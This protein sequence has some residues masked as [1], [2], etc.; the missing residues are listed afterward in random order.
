[1]KSRQV[2]PLI[3]IKDTKN[4]SALL[5]WLKFNAAAYRTKSGY[6]NVFYQF[7]YKSLSERTGLSLSTLYKYV[8]KLIELGWAH[9]R[10]GNLCL[11]GINKYKGAKVLIPIHRNRSKQI[12]EL[13]NAIIVN[14]L[15]KQERQIKFRKGIVQKAESEHGKLTKG[16]LKHLR[17]NPNILTEINPSNLSNQKFG[18]LIDRSKSTG[19]RLQRALRKAKLIQS[20]SRSKTL[21]KGATFLEYIYFL[22]NNPIG[23]IRY[24]NGDIVIQQPNEVKKIRVA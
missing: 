13:R 11:I 15:D 24:F 12:L 8:P 4:H 20:F 7:T 19:Q 5:I 17:K 22:E 2:C 6:S 10:N 23:A 3:L 16:E 21:V 9:I 1:V 18:T 14:N